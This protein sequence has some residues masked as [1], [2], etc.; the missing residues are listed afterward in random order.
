MVPV[1]DLRGAPEQRVQALA[2]ACADWGFFHVINHGIEPQLITSLQAAS[3]QFFDLPLPAK[4]TAS[5]TM[6]NPVGYYDRDL[7]KDRRDR[8]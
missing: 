2:A 3:R 5:R 4:Q 8:K 1:I 7:T 6:D